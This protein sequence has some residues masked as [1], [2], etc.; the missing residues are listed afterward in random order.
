MWWVCH[1]VSGGQGWH[2]LLCYWPGDCGCCI[3]CS[4]NTHA[5]RI[6]VESP[7]EAC[8]GKGQPAATMNASE[9]VDLYRCN[10]ESQIHHQ[11]VEG[12]VLHEDICFSKK[13]A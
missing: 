3:S 4:W 8:D 2:L 7:Q 5:L 13:C 1:L 6:R 11:S 10:S 12:A 9:G